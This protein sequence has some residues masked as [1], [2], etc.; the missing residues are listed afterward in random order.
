MKKGFSKILPF[1][2]GFLML[3]AGIWLS[4]SPV[5][6]FSKRNLFGWK[7]VTGEVSSSEKQVVSNDEFY[8]IVGVSYTES[9]E[10]V[11]EFKYN[12]REFPG[13][14]APKTI[15]FNTNNSL[16]FVIGDYEIWNLAVLILPIAGLAMLIFGFS[17]LNKIKRTQV[18]ETEEENLAKI[19]KIQNSEMQ[20]WG[21]IINVETEFLSNG[22]NAGR[23]I[24]RAQLPSGEW[25]NFKSEQIEGLTAGLLVSYQANPS[26]I[27]ISVRNGDFDDY[28]VNSEEIIA[29]IKKSFETVRDVNIG[30]K[31]V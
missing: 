6:E 25:K 20:I 29:A 1:V 14:G 31:N 11:I 22:M 17:N 16:N 12:S 8:Y 28:F 15:Y 4:I 26:Q 5:A 3:G 9:A 27:S 7:K 13:F 21:T 23:A 10:R 2:L 24:I 30:G 18:F 19:S